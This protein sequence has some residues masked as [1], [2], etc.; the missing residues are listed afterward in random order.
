MYYIDNN[1]LWIGILQ[2]IMSLQVGVKHYRSDLYLSFNKREN[3]IIYPMD[4]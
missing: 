4:C 3:F 2:L 1:S